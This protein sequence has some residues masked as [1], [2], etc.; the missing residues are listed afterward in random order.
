M[1]VNPRKLKQLG[2]HVA[3][4][5]ILRDG[6]ESGC[7]LRT[8]ELATAEDAFEKVLRA[9]AAAGAVAVWCER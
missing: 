9:V 2:R 7:L 4:I 6:S 8:S 3:C 5:F 1:N